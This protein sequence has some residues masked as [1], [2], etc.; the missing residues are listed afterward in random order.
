MC[1]KHDKVWQ[2][3]S[4]SSDASKRRKTLKAIKKGF[5]TKVCLFHLYPPVTRKR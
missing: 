5:Q 4:R 1:A 3:K 2:E